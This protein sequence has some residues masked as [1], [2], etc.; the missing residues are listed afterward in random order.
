MSS[1]ETGPAVMPSG[2]EEV[3]AR[4]SEKRRREATEVAIFFSVLF[5]SFLFFLGTKGATLIMLGSRRSAGC[6]GWLWKRKNRVE[7]VFVQEW[8]ESAGDGRFAAF[9]NRAEFQRREGTLNL[10]QHVLYPEAYL[11]GKFE[12]YT[13]AI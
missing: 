7:Y 11:E 8:L 3:S 5:F 4:Y 2:G 1:S 6:G 10:I 9:P 12:D 13:R